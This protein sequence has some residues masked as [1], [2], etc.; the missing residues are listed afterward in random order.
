MKSIIRNHSQMSDYSVANWIATPFI[1][2]NK[3]QNK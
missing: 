3:K 1:H 2:G